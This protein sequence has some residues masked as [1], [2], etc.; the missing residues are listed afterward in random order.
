MEMPDK[1]K[2]LASISVR[3]GEA[4]RCTGNFCGVSKWCTQFKKE[5]DNA[6]V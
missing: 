3:K 6:E 4:V 2:K 5:Q 1:D